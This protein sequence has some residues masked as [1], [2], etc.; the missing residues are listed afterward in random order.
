[1]SNCSFQTN[2]PLDY[3][4]PH[5]RSDTDLTETDH[6]PLLRDPAEFF[7]DESREERLERNRERP[8]LLR[9]YGARRHPPT[10]IRR[11]FNILGRSCESMN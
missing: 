3:W 6:H 9:R 7:D 8:L 5:H 2:E 11:F 10:D 4:P 1:M